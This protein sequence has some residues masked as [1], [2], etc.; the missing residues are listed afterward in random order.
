[1][2]NFRLRVFYSVAI[3]FNFT[4]AAEEM[5]ITQP[6][7]TKHIKELETELDVKLF[8]RKA[9]K[10]TLTKAGYIVFDHA[11]EILNLDKQ[12]AFNLSTLKQQYAGHLK[13]GASTTIGQYVL[14]P[15][16]A[17]FAE[18]YQD[19][20]LELLNDNTQKI[21]QAL[22]AGEIDLGIVEGTSR[23]GGIKYIPYA[24]DE[25]V[26]IAH[27]SQPLSCKSE[28]TVDELQQL[29]LVLREPGSGS[30]E[31]ILNKLKERNVRLQ[32]LNVVMHLGSTEGIKTYLS[33]SNS[34]GLISINAVSKEIA[35]GEFKVIDIK[36]FE[37]ERIFHII[38]THGKPLDFA[39]MFIQFLEKSDNR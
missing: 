38:H 1:M 8:D 5:C 39:G 13:L 15:L 12:L 7:V 26:L 23:N 4:K 10:V 18:K 17:Q 30:L 28:I 3:H 21:E 19:I 2:S 14:P 9:G 25:I 31:V 32:D 27:T 35:N 22:L 36:D 6:A 16:L 11:Q 29:P 37:I 33:N 34:L 20:K 24:K